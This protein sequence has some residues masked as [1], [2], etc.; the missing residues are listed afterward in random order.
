[1]PHAPYRTREQDLAAWTPRGVERNRYPYAAARGFEAWHGAVV[2]LRGCSFV[3]HGERLSHMLGTIKAWGGG[4]LP[5]GGAG[6]E[7]W[8]RPRS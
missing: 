7:G 8:L 2:M 6:V 3:R 1:M 5:S 4:L